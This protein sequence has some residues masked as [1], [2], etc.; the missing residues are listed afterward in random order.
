MPVGMSRQ[1]WPRAVAESRARCTSA[2]S[3]GVSGECQN[4]RDGGRDLARGADLGGA[5]RQRLAHAGQAIGVAVAHVDAEEHPAGGDV[6]A[7]TDRPRPRRPCRGPARRWARAVASAISSTAAISGAAAIIASRRPAMAEPPCASSPSTTTSNQ[8]LRQRMG[9]DA[10]IEPVVLQ[11]LALF[12]MQF[13]I[14]A[15]S[16]AASAGSALALPADA[17]QLLAEDRAV[18]VALGQ[19]L[20]LGEDAHRGAAAHHRRREAGAFLIGPVDQQQRRLG[21]GAG[22]VQRAHH[23]EPGQHAEHAVEFAARGLGVQMAADGDRRRGTD[24]GPRGGTPCCRA[25]RR[26]A[27]ARRPRPSAG[28]GRG[29]RHRDRSASGGCSRPSACRRSSPSPSG[30]PTAG[31]RTAAGCLR[32]CA[33]TFSTPHHSAMVRAMVRVMPCMLSRPT[34]SSM[35]WISTASGPKQ[36]TGVSWYS[37][38]KRPS[39]RPVAG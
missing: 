11:Q 38:K 36:A 25:G 33:H 35:P 4:G 34:F 27:S 28:T 23:L 18:G 24:R 14:G 21:L 17:L 16:S 30:C 1:R 19:D 15:D 5:R 37:A 8:L 39:V 26:S 10:D 32:S 31:C 29:P 7:R 2:G 3:K 12:D 9:D 13:E 6:A 22:L 20:R